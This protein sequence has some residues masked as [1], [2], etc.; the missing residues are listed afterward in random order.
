MEASPLFAQLCSFENLLHA[1]RKAARGKRS[2]HDVAD[3]EYDLEGWLLRLSRQ[4]QSRTYQPG[5]YRR[6][7][8][9]DPKPRAISAAPFPDR[10]VHHALC[11]VIEPIFER[12]FIA[13]SYA[14]RAGRGIHQALDRCTQFARRY[15]YVLRCDIVQ[16][17]PSIDLIILR[18]ILARTIR[19][20]AVLWLCDQI[21]AG[22]AHELTK[23]YDLV[24]FPDDDLFSASSRPR[25]LPIGNQTSQFWANCYMNVLDQFVKSDLR[26]PAY[27]RYVDDFL[28]FGDD[29]AELHHWKKAIIAFLASHLRLILHEREC[30]VA[31]VVTGIPFLGFQVFP[32]HRRLRRR[33]GVAFARRMRVMGS[34]WQRGDMT[35]DA[36]TARVRGWVAHVAHGDTWHLR[37]SLFTAR[38]T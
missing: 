21:I 25:G 35:L 24:L 4:L 30:V 12:R 22:G 3:F 7:S 14:N 9:C 18:R 20:D 1:S 10:V 15:R 26:C 17:F 23:Q 11:N 6:F 31:P 37:R 19:D 36:L 16:F 32:T 38:M 27:L 13:D 5:S 34:A 33:N 2:R 8:F 29:K 28:L